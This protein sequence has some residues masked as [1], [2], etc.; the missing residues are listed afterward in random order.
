MID[1]REAVRLIKATQA[2]MAEIDKR[3]Q[4][5]WDGLVAQIEKDIKEGK[6]NG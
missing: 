2:S 3:A 5:D 1:Y 6:Y 4:E